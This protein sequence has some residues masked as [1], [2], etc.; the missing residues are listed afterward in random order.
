MT[1]RAKQFA[2]QGHRDADNRKQ[3]Q[4]DLVFQ[5][6]D[7]ER[8]T[9]LHEAVIGQESTETSAS[10]EGPKPPYH[11]VTKIATKYAVKGAA[12]SSADQ[13]AF[14]THLLKPWQ[15]PPSHTAASAK[16]RILTSTLPQ[17][18]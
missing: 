7:H 6:V 1:T 15:S 5:I 4:A 8:P 10:S 11:A 2:Q 18:D 3:A 12:F 13:A 9:R 17:F 14:A 16:A